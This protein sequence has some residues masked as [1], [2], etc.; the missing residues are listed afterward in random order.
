MVSDHTALE[1]LPLVKTDLETAKYR[2]SRT[3]RVKYIFLVLKIVETSLNI[4][5][6]PFFETWFGKLEM[7]IDG[8]CMYNKFVKLNWLAERDHFRKSTS[9]TQT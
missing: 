9:S 4:S 7:T 6:T 8:L 2:Y 5:L 1:S 3:W